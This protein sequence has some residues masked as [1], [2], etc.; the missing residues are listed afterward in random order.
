VTLPE[1]YLVGAPKAGTT[2]LASWLG[3]HPDV[4]WS[5]PKEPYF[6]AADYPGQRAHHG[7]GT[8][9]AYEALFASREAASARLRGEGSTTYLYSRVAVPAILAAVPHARF[10]VCLR[11]PVDL[12][13]S[14]HR[15]QV[16]VLNES[17]PVFADAW[18]R[19]TTGG[20]P[21]TRPL[22]PMLVDYPRVGRLGAAVAR[23]LEV[24]PRD[25]V[26]FVV[27][28]DLAARPR[29]V[30]EA[31]ADFCGI[32]HRFTPS[33]RA[34]NP[35][36]KTYRWSLVQRATLRPPAALAPVMPTVRH[37]SRTTRIQA[38]HRLKE[39]MWTA[40][41]YPTVPAEVRRE[42]TDFFRPDVELLEALLGRDLSAWRACQGRPRVH[43]PR[44]G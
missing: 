11:N 37:W 22:E 19:S 28:D 35:S 24:V 3:S 26:H 23:L 30:W 14:Y 32:D 6:W 4:Y 5:V 42:L 16:V 10:V 8:R 18:R 27:L 17:E 36:T 29:E 12:V 43:T 15:T 40:A 2:S 25:Q 7:F 1:L 31:V 9:S 41:P 21:D 33:F 13:V 39:R 44:E 34:T 38:V 20:L